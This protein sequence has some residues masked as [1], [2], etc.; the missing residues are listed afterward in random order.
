MAKKSLESGEFPQRVSLKDVYEAHIKQLINRA[1]ASDQSPEKADSD[2]LALLIKSESRLVDKLRADGY[3]IAERQAMIQSSPSQRDIRA[4]LLKLGIAEMMVQGDYRVDR[5]SEEIP[6]H[7]GVQNFSDIEVSIMRFL[8]SHGQIS[9]DPPA[10]ERRLMHLDLGCGNM[11][12]GFDR[13]HAQQ[14]PFGKKDKRIIDYMEQIGFADRFYYSLAD[15]FRSSVKEEY[16]NDPVF[17]EFITLISTLISHKMYFGREFEKNPDEETKLLI[18][19]IRNPNLLRVVLSDL[20]KYLPKLSTMQDLGV[21]NEFVNDARITLS[22]GVKALIREYTGEDEDDEDTVKYY[23]SPQ[24]RFLEKYFKPHIYK[25]PATHELAIYRTNLE[26]QQI[27]E[28]LDELK[29]D[30]SDYGINKIALKSERVRLKIDLRDLKR[31]YPESLGKHVNI[32]PHNVV[33]GDFSEFDTV[34]P[35]GGTFAF[36]HSYRAL[37][38]AEDND[39][40]AVTYQAAQ[41]L[42]PGGIMLEDGRRESYTRYERFNALLRLQS[43]LGDDYKISIITRDGQNEAQFATTLIER[44]IEVDGEKV[45]FSDSNRHNLLLQG[46]RLCDL[47]TAM[48]LDPSYIFR[49]LVLGK[50]R[51]VFLDVPMSGFTIPKR[52]GVITPLRMRFRD[53]HPQID[54]ELAKIFEGEQ[55][56]IEW[57]EVKSVLSKRPDDF[58]PAAF[59]EA[60]Q[61]AFLAISKIIDDIGA[62]VRIHLIGA[63]PEKSGFNPIVI[64]ARRDP[65]FSSERAPNINSPRHFQLANLSRNLN[66][67]TLQD[68]PELQEMRD[69]L[70]ANL[71][72]LRELN[73]GKSPI[74]C[75]EL[76]GVTSPILVEELTRIVGD[77]ELISTIKINRG[78][79]LKTTLDD[80]GNSI[81]IIGGSSEQ[82]I[83]QHFDFTTDVVTPLLAGIMKGSNNTVIGI[84]SGSQ[85]L[86]QALSDLKNAMVF[87]LDGA[88]EF[89]PVPVYFGKEV[90]LLSDTS[91]KGC[92]VVMTHHH[93]SVIPQLS[94]KKMGLKPIADQTFGIPSPAYRALDGRFL[95]S[96]FRP[97]IDL[98]NPRHRMLLSRR[99]H[100]GFDAIQRDFILRRADSPESLSRGE[101][102]VSS[103][104]FLS[105]HNINVMAVNELGQK[106]P[107]VAKSIADAYFIPHLL[108]QTEIILGAM[109]SS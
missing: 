95:A 8:A 37:S 62:Q 50:V 97:E 83:R 51:E 107:W 52:R 93:Y 54:A 40:E 28:K 31:G 11:K 101:E 10:R 98:S 47:K 16:V 89:G 56:S 61:A 90:P 41:R 91:A 23:G 45:F 13:R 15:I 29:D 58:L 48:E 38:H 71:I 103:R 19:A 18:A 79:K 78:Q 72:K 108:E 76:L 33:L 88:L 6:P 20:E 75:L 81:F 44:A 82:T 24:K 59:E 27:E 67:P 4:S 17:Q 55:P 53:L 100:R 57:P 96:Q 2:M 109:K 39:Y 25:V 43:L 14:N 92:S 66:V 86:I 85:A 70:V 7:M 68:S 12:A 69:R 21:D 87:L 73:K 99:L 30:D 80:F 105:N 64:P 32:H 74:Q 46:H 26:L 1:E 3:S 36:I 102:E 104:Q 35:K 49:N 77:P 22:P 94:R 84:D 63:V 65:K 9:E 60:A 42:I 106:V 34:M 5:T